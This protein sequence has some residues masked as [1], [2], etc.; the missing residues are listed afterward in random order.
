[1]IL[2]KIVILAALIRLLVVTDKPFHCA[3]LYTAVSMVLTLLMKDIPFSA[4]Y[5]FAFLL[6]AAIRLVLSGLYFY[7][8]NRVDRGLLWWIIL[9]AGFFIVAV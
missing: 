7:F 5:F 3:G 8:L 9:A 1:M 4:A 2:F 6:L